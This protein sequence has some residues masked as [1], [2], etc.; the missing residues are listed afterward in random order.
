MSLKKCDICIVCSKIVKNCHKDIYCKLCNRFV[1]KKCTKLKPKEL[2]C[3][4]NNEWVCQNCSKDAQRDSD[5]DLEDD[6]HNLNESPEFKITNVDFQRYD[7]M[8]FNPLRFD[9]N[10]TK[11]AY[12]DI[13]S[14]EFIHKCPY[15]T[16]EQFSFRFK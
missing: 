4:K 6:V 1:H 5:S 14:E 12:N 8:I 15:L 10:S 13:V 3:L 9:F 7:D 2:K 16:P 11:K